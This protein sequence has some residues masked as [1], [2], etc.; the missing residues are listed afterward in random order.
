[1]SNRNNNRVLG[2][3]GARDLT[4]P[5]TEMVAGGLVVH[6]NICSAPQTSA[7]GDADGCGGDL[8]R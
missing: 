6:T 3:Q 2:R 8:D 5:E 1:M 7:L 4:I